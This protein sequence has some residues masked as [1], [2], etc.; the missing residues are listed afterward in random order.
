M[1]LPGATP[2]QIGRW[3]LEVYRERSR[4]RG[5]HLVWLYAILIGA[6]IGGIIEHY[7]GL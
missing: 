1:L 4:A 2:E 6:L 5:V 3:N 7:V